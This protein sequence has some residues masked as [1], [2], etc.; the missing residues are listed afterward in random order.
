MNTISPSPAPTSSG[1]TP[2][3]GFIFITLLLDVIGLG[4]IIPVIPKLIEELTGEGLSKAAEYGGWLLFSY[5]ICQF[6]FAPVIGG[7]SDRYGRRP[8]LLGSLLGFGFDYLLLAVAPTLSWLFIGRIL[9][10]IL[11]ASFTTGAAY[12]ADVS[13]PEKRAQNFGMI[14]AAFGLG[15]IIG[16]VLGG[17]LGA[18]GS[19]IP[20]YAAAVLTLLNAAYGY[21]ILPESL[22]PE[23]RRPFEWKRANPLG[24]LLNLRRYPSVLALVG[25]LFFVYLASHAVQGTWAYVTMERYGWTEKEVGW[26]LGIV[27]VL[28]AVVQGLLIRVLLP[29][30]GNKRAVFLGMSLWLLGMILF[31][32]A[33]QGWMLMV[34]LIPY[35]LGGISGPAIQ[36]LISGQVLP[37]EQGELQGALTSLM[38]ATS[39]VGPPL[40]TQIFA[41]FTRPGAAVYFPAAPFVAGA[42]LLV[43]AVG[44]L[45]IKRAR[46]EGN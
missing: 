6:L 5:A 9:S 35:A 11:G 28:N 10:G 3:V 16:P 19:R 37:S 2:A 22:A 40:M 15:F 17:I 26:S 32:F 45:Y 25:T 33:S 13:T 1:R 12:I 34:F 20:F 36:G 27:G 4:I 41:Y 38:S 31:V 23:N 39:I 18:Y 8:V 43:G 29:K 46:L 14:G 44:M 7:L 42:V 24:S 30:L 21:F